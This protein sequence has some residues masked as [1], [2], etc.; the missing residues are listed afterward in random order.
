MGCPFWSCVVLYT[1]VFDF[2]SSIRAIDWGPMLGLAFLLQLLNCPSADLDGVWHLPSHRTA[3][4]PGLF[5][6]RSD[7][8]AAVSP[9][10]VV[11]FAVV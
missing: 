10:V 9:L 7:R 4:L 5:C 3:D 2:A 1:P 11:V 6:Q 8:H